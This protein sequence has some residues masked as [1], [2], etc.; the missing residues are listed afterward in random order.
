M[1]KS[2]SIILDLT[3]QETQKKTVFEDLKFRFELITVS[4]RVTIKMSVWRTIDSGFG[5]LKLICAIPKTR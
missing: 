3:V 1:N 5:Y 4:Y 2:L